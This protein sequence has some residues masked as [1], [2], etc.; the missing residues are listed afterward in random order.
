MSKKVTSLTWSFS[1]KKT[2]YKHLNYHQIKLLSNKAV[3][4]SFLEP[5]WFI[6]NLLLILHRKISTL[7]NFLTTPNS[8][9]YKK[10]LSKISWNTNSGPWF[11]KA[12]HIISLDFKIKM[13]AKDSI[14]YYK[15]MSK[16]QRSCGKVTMSCCGLKERLDLFWTNFKRS[17]IINLSWRISVHNNVVVF[18]FL[19]HCLDMRMSQRQTFQTE[20][21]ES[22][23]TIFKTIKMFNLN[24][25]Q[26]EWTC[27]EMVSDFS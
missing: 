2:G 26:T 3:E 10:N 19:S 12:I 21:K 13:T 16:D 11:L 25:M 7:N 14:K 6:Q 4:Y 5:S 17:L 18:Q 1:L 15:F 24:K 22:I 9:D 8:K 23:L 20:C 27:R